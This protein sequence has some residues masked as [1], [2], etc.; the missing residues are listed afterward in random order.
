[1]RLER[2][3]EDVCRELQ[4]FTDANE[5]LLEELVGLNLR[6]YIVQQLILET[7]SGATTSL[8]FLRTSSMSQPLW[9]PSGK[10]SWST[11]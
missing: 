3:I 9:S 6:D 2:Q 1:M 11:C 10:A 8:S 7:D 5:P 4:L